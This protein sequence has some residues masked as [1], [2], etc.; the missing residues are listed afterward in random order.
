MIGIK[1]LRY[2]P[3]IIFK[4]SNGL[5]IFESMFNGVDKCR[6]VIG[7]PH[8]S[9]REVQKRHYGQCNTTRINF[10]TQLSYHS[11][12]AFQDDH[13]L[14][15]KPSKNFS[16]SEQTGSE[17]TYRC[18]TCRQCKTCKNHE[19]I[20]NISIKEEV[21][22]NLIKNSITI[23]LNS[24]IVTAKPPFISNPQIKLL[25]N[26]EKALKI[27]YQQLRKLN[28]EEHLT[29]RTDIIDSERKL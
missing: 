9:F 7:G 29:D 1:Y 20:E 12:L 13:C 15:K 18:I 8:H 21:E 22:Q 4:M 5:S 23:D 11:L 27:Y 17:I 10:P 6:G 3:N 26:K 25:S 14:H 24:K 19:R 28:K 2:H 16:A